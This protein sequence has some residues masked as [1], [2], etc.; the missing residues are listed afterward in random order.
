V[1]FET[2]S[3]III[4]NKKLK[5]LQ[6]V[7]RRQNKKIANLT[8]IIEDLKKGNLIDEDMS[9]TLLESFGKHQDLITN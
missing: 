7:I 6:Q 4:K 8:T 2:C 1:V 3:D 5:S 9:F